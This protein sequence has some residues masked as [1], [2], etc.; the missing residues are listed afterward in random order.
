MFEKL[1]MSKYLQE[2]NR[3]SLSKVIF[4]VR[5]K[6]LDLKDWCP[7]KYDTVNCVACGNYPLIFSQINLHTKI[8]HWKTGSK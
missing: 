2:N 6:T 3:T 5:S 1:E 4:G 8:I 7:W